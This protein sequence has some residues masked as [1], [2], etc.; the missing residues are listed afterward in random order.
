MPISDL[1]SI[2]ENF[3][4]EN[5]ETSYNVFYNTSQEVLQTQDQVVEI[6]VR[7]R[8]HLCTSDRPVFRSYGLLLL[9][10]AVDGVVKTK[11]S[12]AEL[13]SLVP[14][15]IAEASSL[16]DYRN[17]DEQGNFIH[18][19]SHLAY[20]GH[21]LSDAGLVAKDD[22]ATLAREICLMY[23]RTKAAYF[24]CEP[25]VV[26]ELILMLCRGQPEVL[27][28]VFEVFQV[29]KTEKELGLVQGAIFRANYDYLCMATS[30][31]NAKYG[32]APDMP[33]QGYIDKML[34]RIHG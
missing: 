1:I 7:I 30:L 17:F 26:G 13:S 33:I 10:A 6:V 32:I 19:V 22:A 21:A 34:D 18:F 5:A 9:G 3:T 28:S 12:N 4:E 16:E 15:L 20:L 8:Q 27:K 14:Y 24:L 2:I 11:T 25:F 29:Y 23:G 31:M